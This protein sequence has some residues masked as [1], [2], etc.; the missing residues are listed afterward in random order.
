VRGTIAVGALIFCAIAPVSVNAKTDR[1][2]S[3]C[4]QRCNEYYICGSNSNP[5]YCHWAC[6]K[7]C[8]ANDLS[9]IP[10][11]EE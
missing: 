8:H 9:K 10:R 3:K 5:M 6:R 2:T 1:S 11:H 7:K 4:E